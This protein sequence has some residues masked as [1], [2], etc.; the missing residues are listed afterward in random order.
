MATSRRTLH[1]LLCTGVFTMGGGGGGAREFDDAGRYI[2][3]LQDTSCG[4]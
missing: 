2:V 4:Y 3:A 1:R